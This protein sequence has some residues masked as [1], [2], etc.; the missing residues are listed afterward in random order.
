MNL[1]NRDG[2]GHASLEFIEEGIGMKPI[3]KTQIAMKDIGMQLIGKK[4]V[5]MKTQVAMQTKCSISRCGRSICK[6]TG[7]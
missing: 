3:G 6:N 1:F 2:L 4:Q 5:A 7:S